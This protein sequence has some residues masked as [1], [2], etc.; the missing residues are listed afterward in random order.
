MWK[1]GK[2][3]L[4]ILEPLIGAWGASADSPQ[5]KV[6]CTRRFQWILSSS[7]VQMTANWEFTH[8]T[9]EEIALFGIDR[10]KN[11]CFWSFASDGKQSQGT[12]ADV[13]DVHPDA[14]GFEAQMPAGLARMIYWPGSEEDFH[15]AVESKTKKG[16]SRFVEH[17]YV[18]V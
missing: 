2:G 10:D 4:G 9:Y 15:W 13:T 16:W 6:K 14:I 3:K 12:L 18:S 1:K 11:I 5:G 7:Y 8:S 17:H